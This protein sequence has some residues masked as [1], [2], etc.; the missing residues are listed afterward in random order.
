MAVT[1]RDGFEGQECTLNFQDP[2]YLTGSQSIQLFTVSGAVTGAET[3][4]SRPG[5][6]IQVGTFKALSPGNAEWSE[7]YPP[8][9]FD[10]PVGGTTL[11]YEAVPTGDNDA[12]FWNLPWGGLV[13]TVG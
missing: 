4:I 12:V 3:W 13:V 10:C 6:N 5:R 9:T 8:R 2:W 7:S 1:I 11:Y